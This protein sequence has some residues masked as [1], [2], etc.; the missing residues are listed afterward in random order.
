MT[1][2]VHICPLKFFYPILCHK[3][4]FGAAKVS[5]KMTI[6]KHQVKFVYAN[7]DINT[8]FDA[9]PEITYGD[10]NQI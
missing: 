9:D 8:A 4:Q 3:S 5:L 7:L 2:E 6:L 1:V 10:V